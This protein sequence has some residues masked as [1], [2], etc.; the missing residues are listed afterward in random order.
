MTADFSRKIAVPSIGLPVRVAGDGDLHVEVAAADHPGEQL[1]DMG[2]V[3][4]QPRQRQLGEAA[5]DPVAK[6]FTFANRVDLL[7][8]E[9]ATDDETH[10]AVVA[11]ETLDAAGGQRQ[12]TASK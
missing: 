7:A 4:I 6:R 2:D 3:G 12:R 9:G 8:A 5:L 1:Q 11:D 10:A